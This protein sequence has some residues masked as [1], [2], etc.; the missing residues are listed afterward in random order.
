MRA[1]APP[2]RRSRLF[3]ELAEPVWTCTVSPFS[4]DGPLIGHAGPLRP[5]GRRRL[6]RR[7]EDGNGPISVTILCK[8]PESDATSTVKGSYS[9]DRFDYETEN[10]SAMD[11]R[12]MKMTIKIAGRR[13][14]DCIPD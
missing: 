3:C 12:S 9:A 7:R 4:A 5:L 8:M 10:S 14:G 13:T 11:G 2:P 1:T 6:V